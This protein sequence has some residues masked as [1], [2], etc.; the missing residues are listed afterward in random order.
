MTD[1][2]LIQYLRRSKGCPT[3]GNAAAYRIEELTA[4]RDALAEKL[5]EAEARG[6][7]KGMEDMAKTIETAKVRHTFGPRA[8]PQDAEKH[9]AAAYKDIARAALRST[10]KVTGK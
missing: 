10:R 8:T 5:G 4:E 6:W 7:Q 2:D 9:T 1:Q 3:L